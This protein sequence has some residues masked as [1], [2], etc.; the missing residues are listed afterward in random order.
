MRAP[1]PLSG[2]QVRI[3]AAGYELDVASIGA[4][5]RRLTFQGRDLIVPFDQDEL[6]PVYRGA[7]LA[8]WPNRVVDGVYTVAGERRQLALTEPTRLHALHGLTPWLDFGC[9][10]Q[11]SD[12][13]TLAAIVDPQAGYPHRLK[14]T[15]RY[16]LDGRGLQTTVTV[17]HLSAG[18]APV[19]VAPHPYLVA[20][21]TLDEWIL[22][23]PA[24]TVLTVTP[25]RLI[26]VGLEPVAGG[27]FDFRSPRAIGGVEIDHAFTDLDRDGDGMA[28][29]TVTDAEGRGV[30]MSWGEDCPWVQVHTADLPPG[31]GPTR[32]GLA[33]EPMTCP[34]DAFNS[35]QDLQLLGEG[36]SA[37]ASWRL[38]AVEP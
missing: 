32:I 10:S 27:P 36:E 3:A 13:V 25:N 5:T 35:G 8:P 12:A 19:G 14:V 24:A 11:S 23:L 2:Q 9:L 6:R 31:Q 7:I 28:T 17:T 33:V 22:S 4:S 34:P 21:G 30:A 26:P 20:P 18:V 16:Q 38:L 15:V 29:V 1:V 37:S